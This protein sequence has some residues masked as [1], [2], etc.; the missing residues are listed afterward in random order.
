MLLYTELRSAAKELLEVS[1]DLEQVIS[2]EEHFINP[3]FICDL[4]R[5]GKFQE[6]SSKPRP[7][8]VKLNHTID[9]S[10]LL[11]KAKS[12][13]KELRIKRDMSAEER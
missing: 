3:L 13:P 6:L 9:V 11:S 4:L 8:F 1:H 2:V 10:L 12:L 7:I 5:L